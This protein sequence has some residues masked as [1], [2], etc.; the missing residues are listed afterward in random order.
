MDRLMHIIP[1]WEKIT[2]VCSNFSRMIIAGAGF[3]RSS[4]SNRAG[5]AGQ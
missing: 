4:T 5:E 3:G 1:Q 2:L